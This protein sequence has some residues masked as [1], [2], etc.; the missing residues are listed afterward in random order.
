MSFLFVRVG[1]D[2]GVT[3]W[4]EACDSYGCSYASVVACAVTEAFA[5]LLVGQRLDAVEPLASACVS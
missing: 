5:P 1:T 3:G 4:G 2:A